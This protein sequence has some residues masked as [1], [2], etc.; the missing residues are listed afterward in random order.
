MNK[1]VIF[2]S[3]FLI[4]FGLWACNSPHRNENIS[5]VGQDNKFISSI[6]LDSTMAESLAKMPVRCILQEYPNK[7][8]HTAAS[9]EDQLQ[10]PSELHPAFYGCFDWHSSVHGHWMLVRLL[11]TYPKISIRDSISTIFDQTI[12]QENILKEVAYFENNILGSLYERT[13]GWAWILKLDQELALSTDSRYKTYYK[14]LQPLT[15]KIVD[16]WKAYLIKQSYPNKTGVHNNT[17]FA[18]CFAYDWAKYYNDTAFLETIIAK[19]KYF[20]LHQK[21][22]PAHLEPDG[23][24]FFSPSLYVAE[25][26][27]KILTVNE[28]NEWFKTYFTKEGID[29]LCVL[30]HISDRNDYQI[31]HLDG[32]MYSRASNMKAIIQV[33]NTENQYAKNQFH[34]AIHDHLTTALNNLSASN[35]GGEHWLASFAVLALTEN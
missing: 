6:T 29:N 24:D 17:A 32:L 23:S 19:A 30:P 33:L 25:L 3:Q 22:I 31:V 34:K 10:T 15:Q 13:Y 11:N 35:Y 16:L 27:S 12:T 2:T 14:N 20:Y 28:F 21:N 1:A 26:M 9:K 18:L 7:T 4:T 5:P 8:S